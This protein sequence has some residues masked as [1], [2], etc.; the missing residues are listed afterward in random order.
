MFTVNYGG[1]NSSL[2]WSCM[3]IRLYVVENHAVPILN[4]LKLSKTEIL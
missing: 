4:L 3:I 1:R 2:S